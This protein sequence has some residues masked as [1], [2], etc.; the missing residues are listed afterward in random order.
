M[1]AV[2]HNATIARHSHFVNDRLHFLCSLHCWYCTGTVSEQID[3]VSD[4]DAE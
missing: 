2:T 4:E 3:H 1:S